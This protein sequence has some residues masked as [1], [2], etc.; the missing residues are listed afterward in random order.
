MF[1]ANSVV[2]TANLLNKT[3]KIMKDITFNK[4]NKIF[5]MANTHETNFF[6][7]KI[8]LRKERPEENKNPCCQ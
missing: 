1:Q 6:S 7:Q 2:G 4:L 8:S 3:K 5:L